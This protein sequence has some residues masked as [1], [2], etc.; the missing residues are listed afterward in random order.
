MHVCYR[1]TFVDPTLAGHEG[2]LYRA[3]DARV[4]KVDTSIEKSFITQ[5]VLHIKQAKETELE[6]KAVN[7]LPAVL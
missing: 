6:Y 4:Y 7:F 5:A 1:N 3:K 2:A